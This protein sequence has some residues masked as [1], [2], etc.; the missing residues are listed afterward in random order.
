MTK[1]ENKILNVIKKRKYN[2]NPDEIESKQKI[3]FV[4]IPSL[5][6]VFLMPIIFIILLNVFFSFNKSIFSIL[7]SCSI[8]SGIYNVYRII[9]KIYNKDGSGRE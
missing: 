7:I 4:A 5:T 6:L 1:M 2:I 9:S 3:N 8:F